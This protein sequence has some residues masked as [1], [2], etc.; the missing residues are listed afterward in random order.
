MSI[1]NWLKKEPI[2]IE[3]PKGVVCIMSTVYPE[4]KAVFSPH[5]TG[6]FY[7]IVLTESFDSGRFYLDDDGVK[8]FN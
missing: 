1:F 3:K 2:K 4:G 5:G 6:E 7:G 8:Q